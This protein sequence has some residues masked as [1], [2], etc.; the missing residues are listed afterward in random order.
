MRICVADCR[1]KIQRSEVVVLHAHVGSRGLTVAISPCIRG[2]RVSERKGFA[3][4]SVT[5]TDFA[6]LGPWM[7]ATEVLY[8]RRACVQAD[9]V[10][11]GAVTWR[12]LAPPGTQGDNAW[13]STLTRCRAR[14]RRQG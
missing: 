6:L 8:H 1:E 7:S 2:W 5:E 10:A 11:G 9:G 3:H 12:R 4:R 13:T 14:V